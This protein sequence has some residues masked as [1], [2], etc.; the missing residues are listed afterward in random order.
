[1]PKCRRK[2]RRHFWEN[3]ERISVYVNSRQNY[4][5]IFWMNPSRSFWTHSGGKFLTESSFLSKPVGGYLKEYPVPD[6]GRVGAGEPGSQGQ[7]KQFLL[8]LRVF[9]GILKNFLEN[10]WKNKDFF[11]KF[12]SIFEFLSLI[13]PGSIRLSRIEEHQS[14]WNFF[15]FFLRKSSRLC[16]RDSVRFF[17]VERP[18][19][20]NNDESIVYS[21]LNP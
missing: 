8:S 5:T 3:T 9:E 15:H 10:S 13:L 14:R 21:W 12:R 18:T 20:W 11:S 7:V 17:L 19:Y 1:M 6:L 4:Y 16:W 2:C